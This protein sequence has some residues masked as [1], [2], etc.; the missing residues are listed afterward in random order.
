MKELFYM[1]GPKFMAILTLFLIIT[2]AWFIYHFTVSYLAQK[3][4]REK[5]LRLLGYGKLIGLFSLIIG[6]T[7]Q[8]VGLYG[9]FDAIESALNNGEEIIPELVFGGIRV[10][11]IVTIY[12]LLIYLF[13]LLLWFVSTMLIEKR[14]VR[15]VG[16]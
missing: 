14:Q 2:T 1:G 16:A 5:L 3:L 12:G 8:L 15:E 11:M 13:S 10:T 6:I 4:N 9:M 7:G